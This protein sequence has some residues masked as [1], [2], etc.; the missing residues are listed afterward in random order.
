MIFCF[1]KF[2]DFSFEI[3]FIISKAFQI[4]AD[5]L[6]LTVGVIK[7]GFHFFDLSLSFKYFFFVE[8]VD[9]MQLAVFI[10]ELPD[11]DE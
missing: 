3:Q 6:I 4:L 8:L 10:F 9:F 7:V 11:D 2:T 1:F 5:K